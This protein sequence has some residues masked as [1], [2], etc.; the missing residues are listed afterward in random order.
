[1]IDFYHDESRGIFM[2]VSI[3][4][5]KS[6]RESVLFYC[7]SGTAGVKERGR[8]MSMVMT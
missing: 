8:T 6:A 2:P 5:V 3:I 1:M 7:L 4:T